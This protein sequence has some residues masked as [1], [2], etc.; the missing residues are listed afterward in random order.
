MRYRKQGSNQQSVPA[1]F[2]ADSIP[3]T[4]EDGKNELI[5]L[6]AWKTPYALYCGCRAR[7]LSIRRTL[8]VGAEESKT[9]EE[10]QQVYRSFK[11]RKGM[12]HDD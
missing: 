10:A 8:G 1:I 9:S 3:T 7:S 6:V 5:E 12:C 4:P 2:R 11:V